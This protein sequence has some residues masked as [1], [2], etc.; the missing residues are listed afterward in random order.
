M[1]NNHYIDLLSGVES[2]YRNDIYH[3]SAMLNGTTPELCVIESILLTKDKFVILFSTLLLCVRACVAFAARHS[4]HYMIWNL[5]GR[6]Y[7][8]SLFSDMVMEFGWPDH[9]APPLATLFKLISALDSYVKRL[10]SLSQEETY[11]FFLSDSLL[12]WCSTPSD[13]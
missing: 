11:L 13:G 2:T 3:V 8:Y 6:P 12:T 10:S 5:S 9:H 1:L 4:G 7:D